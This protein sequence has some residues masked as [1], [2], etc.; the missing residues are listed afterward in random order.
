MGLILATQIHSPN[1]R[2]IEAIAAVILLLMLW[3]LSTIA[4]IWLLLVIYQF[5]FST[6]Y[7]TSNEVFLLMIGVIALLRM[8]AGEYKL[9]VDPKVRLPLLLIIVSYLISFKNVIPGLMHLSLVNTFSFLCAAT[10]MILIV[11]FIDDEEKLIKTLKILMISAA[12]FI[13]FTIFEMNYPGRTLIPNWLWTQHRTSLVMKGVRMGGP[14]HDYELSAEFF[15][16]NAFLIFYMYLRTKNAVM[17]G[18]YLAFLLLDIFMM[19]TTITRGAF[20]SLIV[21]TAYLMFLSRKDIN[22]VR[23]AYIAVGLSVLLVVMEFV[24][25]NYTTSGSMFERVVATTF[26][27]GLVPKNRGRV[28]YEAFDRGM[29]FPLFGGGAGWDFRKGLSVGDWPHNLYLFYFNITGLFGLL[30]FLFFM[31]RIVKTTISGVKTSL[32]TSSFPEGLM[33]IMHVIIVIFLFDQIKIEYLRNSIY[34]YYIFFLFAL[35]ISTYNIMQKQKRK[36]ASPS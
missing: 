3:R 26:E 21:G 8:S 27:K 33:K 22:F 13:A 7:G 17:R 16:L 11:N 29:R 36:R 10:Y 25:A 15:T 23:F 30:A 1:K 6:S 35:V 31:Y 18:V 32:L 24:V 2:A 34:T 14:Y 5:P 28:W 4:S 20:F 19:F 12:F 9:T